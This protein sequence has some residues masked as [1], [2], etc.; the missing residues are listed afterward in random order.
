MS[1][2]GKT[3]LTILLVLAIV[4]AA[5]WILGG[6][7]AEYS[8]GLSIDAPPE[9]VF[10]YLTQP[11]RLKNW[12]E[13]LV[14]V[15]EFV[16][17]PKADGLASAPPAEKTLRVMS[18]PNGSQAHSQDQVIRYE[19]NLS[20]SIQSTSPQRV[21][22]YIYQLEPKN[23]QTFLSYRIRTNSSGAGRFLAA[24]SGNDFQDR[25]DTD[26]RKL[27]ALV[28]SS[29]L[30]MPPSGVGIGNPDSIGREIPILDVS[31]PN[32]AIPDVSIPDVAIPDVA[33]PDVAIPPPAVTDAETP[34]SGQPF[35]FP[36][37]RE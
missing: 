19:E 34:V 1:A 21:V 20:I 36:P 27:K 8:T 3:V 4:G 13:G 30:P 18:N 29:E 9:A 25:I 26:I 16:P 12:V 14:E 32:G 15:A 7:Q 11:E 2:I 35:S 33:I 22:T 10:P 6:K 37:S 23:G 28:E 17:A 5:L 24:I 31:A